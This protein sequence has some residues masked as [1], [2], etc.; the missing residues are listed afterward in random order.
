MEWLGHV[1]R[2]DETR[3]VKKLFEEKVEGR[4]GRGQPR[5]RWIDDVEEDIRKL[6]I[7]NGEEKLW[8]G[9]NG[10]QL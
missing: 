8:I 4:R 5:L 2:M 9:K 6:G 3:A 7:K 10:R 1:V